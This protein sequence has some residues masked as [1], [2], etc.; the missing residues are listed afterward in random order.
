MPQKIAPIVTTVLEGKRMSSTMLEGSCPWGHPHWAKPHHPAL[1]LQPQLPP[2]LL[3]CSVPA[4]AFPV[5]ATPPDSPACP[6]LPSQIQGCLQGPFTPPST[7][8]MQLATAT[9]SR[10]GGASQ[11]TSY[12]NTPPLPRETVVSREAR[13]VAMVTK[14]GKP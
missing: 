8:E 13:H 7:A 2:T 6:P 10:A 4:S 11:C 1:P 12:P 3:L 9:D 14:R 5:T